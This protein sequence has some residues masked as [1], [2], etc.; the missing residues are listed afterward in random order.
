VV[1]F[2]L[3][4]YSRLAKDLLGRIAGVIFGDLYTETYSEEELPLKAEE[5]GQ[6]E[7]I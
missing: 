5:T 1:A 3:G 2:L 6:G 7:G 4:L